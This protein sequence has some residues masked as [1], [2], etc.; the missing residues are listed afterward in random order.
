MFESA[1]GLSLQNVTHLALIVNE[2]AINAIKR[3]FRGGPG[4]RTDIIVSQGDSGDVS[5]SVVD[6]GEP[7]RDPGPMPTTGLGLALVRRLIASMGS[8]VPPER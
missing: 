2:L 4:G 5:I 6:D 7:M 3:A 8:L 1:D